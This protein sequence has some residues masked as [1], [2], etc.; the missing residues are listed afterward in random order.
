MANKGEKMK[1]GL[2]YHWGNDTICYTQR[3]FDSSDSIP[4]GNGDVAINL[5]IED[6]GDLLFLIAKSDA[7]S[8][9]NQLLKL[10]RVRVSFDPNPFVK[11]Q[12]FQLALDIS[13]GISTITAG[14]LLAEIW[15]DAHAPNIRMRMA[16]SSGFSYAVKL[17][18]WRQHPRTLFTRHRSVWDFYEI[19]GVTDYANSK[20]LFVSLDPDR[21][22]DE[23]NA[24]LWAHCNPEK[25]VWDE[26]VRDTGCESFKDLI[27]NPL[28]NRITGGR[29]FSTD[30]ETVDRFLLKTPGPV[31]QSELTVTVLSEQTPDLDGW[32]KRIRFLEAAARDYSEA[33]TAHAE[34]WREKQDR[35]WIRPG[36][37]AE[38]EHIGMCYELQRYVMH[39]AGRG[40]GPIHFNGSLFNVD[41]H[42]LHDNGKTETYNADYRRWGNVHLLQNTRLSYWAM[43]T[44]GD[45]E[46]M[47]P[48]FEW[49][50]NVLPAAH[51]KCEMY[52]GHE[53]VVITDNMSLWGAPP[54]GGVHACK[55]LQAWYSG[56]QHR[57]YSPV[58]EFV[59]LALDYYE[60]FPEKAFLTDTLLPVWKGAAQ[61]YENHFKKDNEGKL[62]ICGSAL[63]QYHE[64]I[65][66]LPDVA[67]LTMLAGRI[68]K[69]DGLP[70]DIRCMTERLQ[71]M[72]PEIPLCTVGTEFPVMK[73]RIAEAWAP[74]GVPLDAPPKYGKEDEARIAP[75]EKILSEG[76]NVEN[77]ELYA[78]FP[79][80]MHCLAN[81]DV[82]LAKRSFMNRRFTHDWG[83]AQ[84]PIQAAL[85]GLTDEA[86]ARVES[87][88]RRKLPAASFPVFWD[89]G[90]D[91]APDQDNGGVASKALQSML[92]QYH[93]EKIL[94]FPAWP[95]E[96][97]VT[98]KVFAPYQ[99]VVEGELFNGRLMALKVSPPERARDIFNCAGLNHPSLE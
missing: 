50:R 35:H 70:E 24:L 44:A 27:P 86:K 77:P 94:L 96:W 65:N 6:E 34:W 47:E 10:G 46:F 33:K 91:W 45:V 9:R 22:F 76:W 82:E 67:G 89:I 54:A 63:E 73:T 83:W 37:T 58:L 97:N 12:P 29:I 87:R 56:W 64:T 17:E 39:C 40:T 8:E 99:T 31:S 5:W 61:L 20:D 79:Y 36:G 49:Y 41:W 72:I 16:R 60:F 7:F 38:A 28:G 74:I 80:R 14:D 68:L 15:V 25:T 19:R 92:I 57:Y 85:C 90:F 52:Y 23:E 93:G 55:D 88:C 78:I 3:G 18:N 42:V 62:I 95:K 30:L 98:F 32:K 48:F 69:I 13:T 11:G 4:L 59:M 26:S 1:K 43:L 2:P 66:P 71:E 21:F 84:D 75:A 51:R 53:G 81:G